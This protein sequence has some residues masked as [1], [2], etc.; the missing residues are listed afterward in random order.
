MI[1]LANL[2]IN[3][4]PFLYAYKSSR[5]NEFY[6]FSPLFFPFLIFNVTYLVPT[7]MAYAIGWMDTIELPEKLYF[8]GIFFFLLGVL[9][10]GSSQGGGIKKF[11]KVVFLAKS[12]LL[13]CFTFNIILLFF[14]GIW[15]GVTINLLQGLSVEDLR[16][17]AEI[18]KGFLKE[19]AV[20]MLTLSGLML[21]THY[22]DPEEKKII[23][24]IVLFLLIIMVVI[25]FITS[26]HKKNAL[27]P[28]IVFIAVYNKIRSLN[29]RKLFFIFLFTF[30]AIGAL[31][32]VR[33]GVSGNVGSKLTETFLKQSI[34][35]LYVYN[36]NYS[37]IV[38]MV[39]NGDLPLQYGKEYYEQF[40]YLIPR[41]LYKDKPIS[42]DYYLKELTNQSFEG[43]GSPP[44]LFG[45]LYLNFGVYGVIIGSFLMGYL[46]K[47]LFN[48][49][50]SCNL[51]FSSLIVLTMYYILNPSQVINSLLML[52]LSFLCIIFFGK[53]FEKVIHLSR[54]QNEVVDAV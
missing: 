14:Y 18:G 4:I 43:G 36:A 48:Y 42:F 49:Y 6:F 15:S 22:I 39:Y 32:T 25:L 45:S 33:G 28:V 11:G 1:V 24:K 52:Y 34:V 51:F 50:K 31:N 30:I 19:P 40:L 20:N 12:T 54:K 2:I 53:F 3:L 46:Y 38:N 16:R 41:F 29:F 27:L 47:L 10:A 5:K 26:G 13:L 35:V 17:T 21:V 8:I 23:V 9:F 44:T 37:P 7:T